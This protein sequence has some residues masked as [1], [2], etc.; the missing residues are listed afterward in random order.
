MLRQKFFCTALAASLVAGL[1]AAS[2]AEYDPED[3][4]R[5]FASPVTTQR[6]NPNQKPMPPE[7]NWSVD[8]SVIRQQIAASMGKLR[9]GEAPGQA[10]LISMVSWVSN[11]LDIPAIY[12]L[13]RVERTPRIKL[14]AVMHEGQ[15]VSQETI[16]SSYNAE[17]KTIY[18][19]DDWNGATTAG[20]SILVHEM[21]HH[22]QH[23]AGAHYD[24]AQWEEK[25]AYVA[26]ERWLAAYGRNLEKDFGI[27]PLTYLLSTECYIP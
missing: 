10:V 5:A 4:A 19:P 6:T 3:E 23:V 7:F 16:L 18:L 22:L 11:V 12:D 17:K 15:F 26:Q 20:I 8:E 21:A 24:C 9:P 14:A 13:P 2:A 27:D 25:L 1:I